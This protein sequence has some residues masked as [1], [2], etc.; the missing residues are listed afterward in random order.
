MSGAARPRGALR[1]GLPL[2]VLTAV[3]LASDGGAGWQPPS[4]A[5]RSERTPSARPRSRAHRPPPPPADA[6]LDP[7]RAHDGWV[8]AVEWADRMARTDR[9]EE[10]AATL[11]AWSRRQ[12]TLVP[13]LAAAE[14]A[15]ARHAP[16]VPPAATRARGRGAAAGRFL[17]WYALA[18]EG[19]SDAVAAALGAFDRVSDRLPSVP[20][21]SATLADEPAVPHSWARRADALVAVLSPAAGRRRALAALAT[22]VRSGR[23]EDRIRSLLLLATARAAADRAGARV[24][25]RRALAGAR[26]DGDPTLVFLAWDLLRGLRLRPSHRAFDCSRLPR[27]AAAVRVECSL[28]TLEQT[29]ELGDL[30][31]ALAL[32]PQVAAACRAQGT[33]MQSLRYASLSI[34]LSNA[35]GY[36]AV[37]AEAAAGAAALAQR[38]GQWSLARAFLRARVTALRASGREAAAAAVQRRLQQDPPQPKP[39][40]AWLPQ[41]LA[42]GGDDPPSAPTE[43]LSAPEATLLRLREGL[44]RRGDRER[45]LRLVRRLGRDWPAALRDLLEALVRGRYADLQQR[46][47]VAERARAEAD[48]AL[49]AW[50]AGIRDPTLRWWLESASRRARLQ[51][52]LERLQRGAAETALLLSDGVAADAEARHLRTHLRRG[53]AVLVVRALGEQTWLWL[54]ERD[55]VRAHR[56]A[57]TPA[58][59]RGLT[60]MWAVAVNGDIAGWRRTGAMLAEAILGEAIDGGWLDGVDTLVLVPDL[61]LEKVALGALPDPRRP[62]WLGDRFVWARA[63]NLAALESAYHAPPRHGPAAVF[64]PGA[65]DRSEAYQLLRRHGGRSFR[66]RFATADRFLQESPGA[67]VIH[68]GGHARAPA[69]DAL[70]GGLQFR[71][72][73]GDDGFLPWGRIA[74]LDLRGSAVV[75]LGC[76]TAGPGATAAGGAAVPTSLA[77]AFLAAGSRAV[78]GTLWPVRETDA[79]SLAR[80]LYRSGGTDGGAAALQRA[81]ARLRAAAPTDPR[82]WAA[83]VWEG[84]PDPPARAAGAGGGRTR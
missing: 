70:M 29:I 8:A 33:A 79:A 74:A 28:A 59:L 21:G 50:I 41:R 10:A 5:P 36:P 71:P 65:A 37:A 2:V 72:R 46:V 61:G 45:L 80:A 60:S 54:L 76:E 3:L 64:L 77:G 56:L 39:S 78:I 67:A 19:W 17:R 38:L 73:S 25:A 47:E 32:Q 6:D 30:E 55:R 26:A 62:G 23:A 58:R 49:R 24:L 22:S 7:L 75:L 40:G 44:A 66:G 15:L 14:L 34:R 42:A 11:A 57:I 1:R 81:R 20:G 31:R 48:R 82:L 18:R 84:V 52:A 83:A 53:Q 69:V 63:P 27:T 13:A 4:P 9:A 16:P 12:P 43:R 51:S 68:F 35:V